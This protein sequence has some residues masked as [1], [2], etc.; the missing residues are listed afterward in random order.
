MERVLISWTVPNVITVW[1]MVFFG[2]LLFTLT[3]QF[4]LGRKGGANSVANNAGG[5]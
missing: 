5:Y 2:F 3:T 4:I 1:L